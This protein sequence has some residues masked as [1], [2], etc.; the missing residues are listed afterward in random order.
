MISSFSLTN[1]L[2]EIFVGIGE[3]QQNPISFP[4][5]ADRGPIKPMSKKNNEISFLNPY[6]PLVLSSS[7]VFK[8]AS[9]FSGKQINDLFQPTNYL[10]PSILL[11]ISLIQM[12]ANGEVQP[13]ETG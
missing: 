11:T 4:D 3:K 6:S 2:A 13:F 5:W 12:G 1:L 10:T 7:L 8:K 9:T